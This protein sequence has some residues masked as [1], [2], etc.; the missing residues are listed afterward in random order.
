MNIFSQIYQQYGNFMEPFIDQSLLVI[1]CMEMNSM[2]EIIKTNIE[3]RIGL[4][5]M[6]GIYESKEN[7][8]IQS[9]GLKLLNLLM[10]NLDTE[11]FADQQ[12]N[13]FEMFIKILNNFEIRHQE[14]DHPDY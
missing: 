8:L 13:L 4:N 11:T 6:I 14:L 1:E 5:V 12:V 10:K 2:I 3:N 9:V 7:V